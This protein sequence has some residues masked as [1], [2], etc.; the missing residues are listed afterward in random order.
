MATANAT[1]GN[2][3]AK[4]SYNNSYGSSNFDTLSQ[5]ATDFSKTPYIASG[6]NQS[7]KSQGGPSLAGNSS[8]NDISSSLY[9]KSHSNMNKVSEKL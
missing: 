3:F 9:S 7:T 2:Q 6:V 4:P 1:S 5:S 8:V